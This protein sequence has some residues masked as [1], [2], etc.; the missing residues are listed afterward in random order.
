MLASLH[1]HILRF[2][3]SCFYP[4]ILILSGSYVLVGILA[5]SY[6]PVYESLLV[7]THPQVNA[8]SIQM[9]DCFLASSSS[10]A[11]GRHVNNWQI[12]RSRQTFVLNIYG[13]SRKVYLK[14][15]LRAVK[16]LTKPLKST[17]EGIKFL[18]KLD[19]KSLQIY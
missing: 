4:C 2:L 6:T 18:E 9:K 19:R 13:A 14:Q 11:L 16:I 7:C 17:C 10:L 12:F 1:H 8:F 15:P 5:S 3:C